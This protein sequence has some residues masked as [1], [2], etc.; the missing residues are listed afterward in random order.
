MASKDAIATDIVCG[1]VLGFKENELHY[2]LLAQ[3]ALGKCKI[4]LKGDKL[5]HFKFQKPT[6]WAKLMP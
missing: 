4:A 6:G 5:K 2:L 3:E 1:K